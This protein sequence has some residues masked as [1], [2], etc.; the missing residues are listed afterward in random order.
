MSERESVALAKRLA[1]SYPVLTITGPRQSGKTTLARRLFSEKPY[2]NFEDIETRER[3]KDDPKGFLASLPDG[4]V[5]DEVQRYPDIL[6]YIQVAVDAD[7][8]RHFVL[9]GSQQ[10]E[11]MEKLTQS[12]AGRTAIL[13]LLPFS[14]AE[15]YGTAVPD[16]DH[17]VYTGGYPRI[18][19]RSLNPTEAMSFYLSTYVER[20]IRSLLN[21]KDLSR[22]DTFVKLLAGRTAQVL[23]LN[24]L[25]AD[26]GITHATAKSWLTLLETSMIVR[27]LKPWHASSTKRLTKAPKLY[28]LD[29]GLAAYLLGIREPA[30]VKFHPL[31]GALFETLMY[32]EIL[33]YCMNHGIWDS[34]YFFRDS[35]ANEVDFLIEHGHA[36]DAVEVKSGETI[37]ADSFKGL[38]HFSG[39]Y[40]ACRKLFLIYGGADERVQRGA[41]IL[42]WKSAARSLFL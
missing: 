28:F 5:F 1:A 25:S 39:N 26:A 20:D 16:I 22:F 3:I 13:T 32:T 31:R 41:Q 30:Q 36:A 21:V 35:N 7:T 33:K 6:S 4:A 2:F 40:D 12:L 10:F 11:M 24:S 19:D 27:T 29:T 8:R 37:S 17:A 18:F 23:N 34:L 38:I 42:C 9:T 14:L 15:A